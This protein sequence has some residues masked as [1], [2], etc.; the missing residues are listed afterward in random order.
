[1]EQR[2]ALLG[3]LLL[4]ILVMRPRR[5]G[6]DAH[7]EIGK[8]GGNNLRDTLAADG[9]NASRGVRNN[10]QCFLVRYARD[11]ILGEKPFQISSTRTA[12]G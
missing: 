10:L 5:F 2:I 3:L 1:M 11:G 6:I 4:D 7:F 12:F 8:E 9:E